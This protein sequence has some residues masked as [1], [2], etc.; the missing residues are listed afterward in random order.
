MF[1]LCWTGKPFRVSPAF[2]N[3]RPVPGE[4]KLDKVVEKIMEKYQCY[5]FYLGLYILIHV[6]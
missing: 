5:S 1:A 2:G 6:T 3:N 4:P